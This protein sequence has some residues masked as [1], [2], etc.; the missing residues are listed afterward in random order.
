MQVASLLP[1]TTVPLPPPSP[2]SLLSLC[3]L[4]QSHSPCHG[5]YQHHYSRHHSVPHLFYRIHALEA[6]IFTFTDIHVFEMFHSRMFVNAICYFVINLIPSKG[7]IMMSISK[8]DWRVFFGLFFFSFRRVSIIII[9]AFC[10]Y[11]H[12]CCRRLCQKVFHHHHWNPLR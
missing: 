5:H 1:P 7:V 9:M 11:C 12:C 8:I 3:G 6:N 2:W 10:H 4:P